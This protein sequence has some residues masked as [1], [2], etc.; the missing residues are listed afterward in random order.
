MTGTDGPVPALPSIINAALLTS[1]WS[2]ASSDL[3]TSSRALYGM[4]ITGSAPRIF[5]KTTRWGLPWLCF[6]VGCGFSCL[7]YMTVTTEA[8]NVFNY[9]V[10]LTTPRRRAGLIC[11]PT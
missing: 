2:A 11:R 9:F 4:A 8:G 1:A 5:D 7:A 6:I 3:Y 10:R